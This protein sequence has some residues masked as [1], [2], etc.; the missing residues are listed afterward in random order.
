MSAMSACASYPGAR[1]ETGE[2]DKCEQARREPPP[3]RPS[4]TKNPNKK[5]RR[6]LLFYIQHTKCPSARRQRRVRP[7]VIASAIA[8]PPARHNQT[9]PS[10]HT[11][12]NERGR[13]GKEVGGNGVDQQRLKKNKKRELSSSPLPPPTLAPCPLSQPTHT[14]RFGLPRCWFPGGMRRCVCVCVCVYA[15]LSAGPLSR[16]PTNTAMAAGLQGCSTLHLLHL[17]EARLV[18]QP[19]QQ[20]PS[21]RN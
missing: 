1:F 9:D 10:A 2:P 7:H 11:P 8:F 18:H 5:H 19:A 6:L 17:D 4:P 14:L 15:C 12:G 3:L 21:P 13:M 16:A 20:T